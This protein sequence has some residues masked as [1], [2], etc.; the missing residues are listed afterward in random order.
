[1]LWRY[2]VAHD[3][4]DDDSAVVIER[5]PGNGIGL[6]V[7][8]AVLG[9]GVALLLAPQSGADTQYQMRRLARKMKKRARA[10]ANDSQEFASDLVERGRDAVDDAMKTGRRA[11]RDLRRNG[12]SAARDARQ[13]LENRLAKH[14][15][16]NADAFDGEDDGV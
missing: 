14:R 6:F 9:A 12:K 5:R 8:G 13:A 10:L 4:D 7:L 11:A 1:M 2:R 3:R 15:D 16:A